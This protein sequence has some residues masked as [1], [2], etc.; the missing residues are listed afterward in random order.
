MGI[1]YLPGAVEIDV[2]EYVTW[3]IRQPELPRIKE[4]DQTKTIQA[5]R[6]LWNLAHSAGDPAA[7]QGLALCLA[8]IAVRHG[9]GKMAT[10]WDCRSLLA[11]LAPLIGDRICKLGI[12]EVSRIEAGYPDTVEVPAE[13]VNYRLRSEGMVIGT[14][15]KPRGKPPDNDFSWRLAVAVEALKESGCI[16]HFATLAE[17]LSDSTND[18]WTAQRIESRIKKNRLRAVEVWPE[19]IWKERFWAERNPGYWDKPMPVAQPF[20]LKWNG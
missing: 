2:R 20:I 11:N 1:S 8:E 13:Y 12:T 3:L 14:L 4:I 18:N 16:T 19:A 9:R 5:A 7:I 15:K 17:M 6:L 10:P